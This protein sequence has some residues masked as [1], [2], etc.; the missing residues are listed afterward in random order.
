MDQSILIQAGA[1]AT[2]VT[3]LFVLAYVYKMVNH[4]RLRSNCC[5]QRLD[6]SV[7]IDNTTPIDVKTQN[8]S[9]DSN[10]N[11]VVSAAKA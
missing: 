11:G 3:I 6:V 9:Q 7:D 5:G 4:K 1:S 8:P 10:V 2:T